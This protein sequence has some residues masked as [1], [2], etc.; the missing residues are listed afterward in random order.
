MSVFGC[1]GLLL[2]GKGKWY[3]WVVNLA[4]QPV[5]FVFAFVTH[6]YALLISAVLYSVVFA[7]NLRLALTPKA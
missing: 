1:A 2:V 4:A 6:A 7:R 5:W 3:G